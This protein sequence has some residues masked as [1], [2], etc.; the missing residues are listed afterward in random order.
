MRSLNL[1]PDQILSCPSCLVPQKGVADEYPYPGRRGPLSR[2]MG[3][4]EVCHEPFV[5]ERR[6]DGNVEVEGA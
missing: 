5:A 6:L 3:Q 2:F 1:L 4:C